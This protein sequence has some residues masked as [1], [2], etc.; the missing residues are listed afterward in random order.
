MTLAHQMRPPALTHPVLCRH[1][2]D[3]LGRA[4][5]RVSSRRLVRAD[6]PWLIGPSAGRDVVGHDWVER[7]ATDLGGST[8]TGPDH[9]LL[10]SFAA[11]AGDVFDP[12][13]VDP[14]IADFYEHAARWKLDLWSEWSAVAWPFGR[15]ITAMLSERLQ[16]ACLPMHPLDVSHGM[17][18]EVV[19][20]HDAAGGVAGAAWLR[21]MVKTGTVTYSGL[22]GVQSLPASNQPSVRVVFPLPLGSIQIFLAPSAGPDGSFYLRSPLGKFGDN[23]AYLVLERYDETI[24]VRRIP[25]NE[26]FHL[27]VDR[28]GDVR[29]DHSLKLWTIPAVKLH[30]RLQ[31][32]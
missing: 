4:L 29:A 22:Y 28:D 13:D 20:I 25:L 23:G 8:S 3:M 27:Y 17:S 11:L 19:H 9:G 12:S 24:S 18:S 16:Q 7:T 14:R 10:A 26:V 5:M 15:L 31:R 2:V 21:N 6:H 1:P 30:Y 32:G